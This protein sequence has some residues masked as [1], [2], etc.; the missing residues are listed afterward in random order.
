MVKIAPKVINR[1]L[2]EESITLLSKISDISEYLVTFLIRT[3]VL[4]PNLVF[5][6]LIPKKP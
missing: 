6:F 1:P 3:K 5:L 4:R 2:V